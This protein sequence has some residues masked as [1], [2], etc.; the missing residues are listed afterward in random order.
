MKSRLP[1][2]KKLDA[3]RGVAAIYVAAGH[4][5]PDSMGLLSF[6]QEAVIVFFLLS[7]FVIE[8]SSAD[9]LH[10]GFGPYFTKRFLR[11]YSVLLSL[12]L[13]LC[14][15]MPDAMQAPGFWPRLLGNVLMLQDFAYAKPG[16]IVSA[17]FGDTP[18][19]SLHYE[20]WFYMLYFPISRYIARAPLR[21]WL[22][23][24]VAV[25]AALTYLWWPMALNRLLMNVPIWWLGVELARGYQEDCRLNL[26][27]LAPLLGLTALTTAVL[28]YGCLSYLEHGRAL[29]PGLHPLLEVRHLASSLAILLIA[30]AWQR[31]N[32]WGFD[33]LLGWGRLF[34]PISYSLYISHVPLFAKASYLQWLEQP[35]L[36]STLYVLVTVGFC[37]TSELWLYPLLKRGFQTRLQLSPC[38]SPA[39]VP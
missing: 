33:A 8:Y 38:R 31:V 12:F 4:I 30:S 19:W 28:A 6:G 25:S 18:L 27:R 16:V 15:L 20:W 7:G 35:L 14:L 13:L 32:W 1:Q 24:L 5:F 21:Q 9:S 37:L 34:A 26:R 29:R 17:A 2:I 11:I 36:E 23:G 10:R 39:S 22:V 3:V